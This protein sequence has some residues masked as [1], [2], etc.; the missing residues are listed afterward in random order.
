[1][2]S[3]K[4]TITLDEDTVAAVDSLAGDGNRSSFIEKAVSDRLERA[5]RARRA[6]DWLAERAKAEHPGE[7]DD[8]LEA[9]KAADK[10]RGYDTGAEAGSSP[11]GHAA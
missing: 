7:W 9:V 3:K 6:I 10:R 1:M 2:A 4:V 8:A 11:R 5:V